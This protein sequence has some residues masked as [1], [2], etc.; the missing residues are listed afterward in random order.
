MMQTRWIF[1]DCDE[2]VRAEVDGHWRKMSPRV[3]RLLKTIPEGVRDLCISIYRKRSPAAFDARAVIEL[4]SRTLM[5]GAIQKDV[6]LLIDR[7]VDA[8][9]VEIRRYRCCLRHEW[10][11][12][13]KNRRRDELTTAGPLLASD[14]RERRRES[15]FEVLT[16][17]LHPLKEHA[18]REIRLLEKQ[19]TIGRGEVTAGDL[20]SE[21]VLRAW[22]EFDQRPPGW[23]L[24]VWLMDLMDD[25]LNKLRREPKWLPLNNQIL[26]TL[27]AK[28][29]RDCMLASAATMEELLPDEEG[30]PSWNDLGPAHGN[31]I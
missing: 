4:P 13:R 16:P 3:E 25:C 22:E 26:T 5:V 2:A 1:H 10:V 14:R 7:L 12:Q 28:R 8:L 19:G 30:S 29:E 17:I 23:E 27:A 21:V 11:S 20:L 6:H 24:D 31:R 18:R 9:A 15:F